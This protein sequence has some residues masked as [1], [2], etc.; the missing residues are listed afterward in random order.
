MTYKSLF[1]KRKQVLLFLFVLLLASSSIS[2][3]LFLI[4]E[5]GQEFKINCAFYTTHIFSDTVGSAVN[6]SQLL[7][8]S[9]TEELMQPERSQLFKNISTYQASCKSQLTLPETTATVL[10]HS[11]KNKK[12]SSLHIQHD[13]KL[14][15]KRTF[16]CLALQLP[17][18]LS[19]QTVGKQSSSMSSQ[20]LH[21]AEATE[22]SL[23]LR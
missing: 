9:Q 8:S 22:T 6:L 23:N 21:R 13:L 16:F 12:E 7:V 4:T 19:S 10:N 2:S 20:I 1:R 14:P 11:A 5:R 17:T 18:Q 15:S 3:L